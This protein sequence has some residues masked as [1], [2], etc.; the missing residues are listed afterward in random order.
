M[1]T[2]SVEFGGVLANCSPHHMNILTA[3]GRDIGLAFQIVD[4]ILDVTAS[5]LKH[6]RSVGSD[7]ANRKTTYVTLMGIEQSQHLA[8]HLFDTAAATLSQLPFDT[9]LL[10]IIAEILVHRSK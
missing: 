9:Q 7:I 5:T 10:K 1:I 6:G 8:N 3:F 2:A 4:D